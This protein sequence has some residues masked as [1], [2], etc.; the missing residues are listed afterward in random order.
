[1]EILGSGECLNVKPDPQSTPG[2]YRE[3]AVLFG[4]VIDQ[5]HDEDGL[6]DAGA[7]EQADLPPP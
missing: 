7:A 5:F 4:D 3:T 6:A 1:L 2:E